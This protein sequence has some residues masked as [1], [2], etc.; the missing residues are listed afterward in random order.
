[1]GVR[2]QRTKQGAF[3]TLRLAPSRLPSPPK[4]FF[5]TRPIPF[6]SLARLVIDPIVEMIFLIIIYLINMNQNKNI[7]RTIRI[8]DR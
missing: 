5:S 8:N 1:M 2:I 6:R 7:E 4:N 3:L